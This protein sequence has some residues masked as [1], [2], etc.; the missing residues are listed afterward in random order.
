M[1][2]TRVVSST[3]RDILR[4]SMGALH[5]I[6]PSGLATKLKE[7]G[8]LR[9]WKRRLSSEG[10]LKNAHYVQFYTDHFGLQ[11]EY[12]VGKKIMDIG[13]G[14]RGS[15]EWADMTAERVG[16][17]PLADEY[18]KL[19]TARHKMKYVR[20][21]AEEIPFPDGYFDC[22][23]SFNS[24]DHVS[25]LRA[26]IQSIA[27]VIRF[28]GDFLLLTDVN[29]SATVNEPQE[30]CWDIVD[31]FVPWFDLVSSN[32]FEKDPI[33][34]YE[35]VLRGVRWNERDGRKRYGVLSARFRKR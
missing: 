15:L 3:I 16:L 8:E 19:G 1:E 28:G 25:D 5:S 20:G 32:R 18:L 30:F 11:P 26:A 4:F 10:E 12:Y 34:M 35:S 9:Y 13:C 33:G 17:D 21:T 6:L 22:I 14:P 7:F 2:R 24:L 31:Q 27:R 29:H 23:F